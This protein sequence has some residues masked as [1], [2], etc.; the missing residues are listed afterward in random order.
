VNLTS[1]RE[2]VRETSEALRCHAEPGR[3]GPLEERRKGEGD[4]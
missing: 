1:T 4:G 3:W 2:K